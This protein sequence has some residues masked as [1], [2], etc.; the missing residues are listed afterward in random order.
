MLGI[1]IV[2]NIYLINLI[3][4]DDAFKITIDN[5]FPNN[6]DIIPHLNKNTTS[7]NKENLQ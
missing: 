5:V 4:Q 1:K 2:N 7:V 6:K 3:F